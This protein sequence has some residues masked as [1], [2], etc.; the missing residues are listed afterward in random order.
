MIQPTENTETT[1]NSSVCI[2]GITCEVMIS[3]D[4][5]HWQMLLCV[6]CMAHDKKHEMCSVS[7]QLTGHKSK[8][9]FQQS[10]YLVECT[11]ALIYTTSK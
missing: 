6:T 4:D 8:V 3:T 10:K 11:V 7:H 1:K 5:K 2:Y 9:N